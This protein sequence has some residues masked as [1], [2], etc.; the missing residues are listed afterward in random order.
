MLHFRIFRKLQ[1]VFKCT[2]KLRKSYKNFRKQTFINPMDIVKLSTDKQ[3]TKPF[4]NVDL[5]Y[6]FS[7]RIMIKNNPSNG[8][9]VR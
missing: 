3:K 9:Y 1:N 6:I 5:I 7:A 4:E 8:I 2:R